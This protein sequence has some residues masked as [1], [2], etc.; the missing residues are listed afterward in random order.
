VLATIS[1]SGTKCPLD[2]LAMGKT[3]RAE[4]TQIG[5]VDEHWRSHPVSG[6]M[7]SEI[8]V[9]SVQQLR[10]RAPEDG[11]K[12]LVL[13]LHSS[14]RTEA[15]RIVPASLSIEQDD[16]PPRLTDVLN[17]MLDDCSAFWFV[18][19]ECYGAQGRLLRRISYAPESS[20]P[21]SP[22][23]LSGRFRKAS[24]GRTILNHF[25]L[26]NKNM[27]IEVVIPF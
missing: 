6:C 5:D 18:T 23:L 22:W 17:L 4:R 8:F 1:A 2:F 16:I 20:C 27:F 24:L 19:I 21:Q 14:R 10:M 25:S 11:V 7:T 9:D 12:H 3:P 13:D 26:S 15:V